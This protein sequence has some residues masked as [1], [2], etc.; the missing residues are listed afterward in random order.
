MQNSSNPEPKSHSRRWLTLGLALTVAIVIVGA[1]YTA[2]RLTAMPLP[3]A[4]SGAVFTV[5]PGESVN[6]L[7]RRLA[8]RGIL[9]HAWDLE[10]LT[11]VLGDGGRVRAG[12]Y[13]VDASMSTTGLLNMLVAGQVLMHSFTIVPGTTFHQVRTQLEADT[14]FKDDIKGLDAS[15]IADLIGHPGVSP[16]GRL[17]PQTYDFPRGTPASTVIARAWSAMQQALQPLWAQ[18]AADLP[19]TSP[20]QALVLASIIEKETALAS[21]RPRIAGV[22]VRRLRRGMYLDADPTV[23]YGLGPTFDGDITRADLHRA[24]PYNTYV[25]RGLPPTPI[26][27]PSVASIEAALHPAAGTALYFVAKGNGSHVFSDTLAEQQKMIEKYQLHKG[28]GSP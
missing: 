3:A 21:E 1:G 13:R 22:F 5:K 20:A 28:P 10:L 14:A 26:C 4:A 24:T 25:H 7:A 17:L 9:R 16:E 12:E 11:R 8:A 19:Y 27:M 23:I 6:R 15:R 18:R 2:W